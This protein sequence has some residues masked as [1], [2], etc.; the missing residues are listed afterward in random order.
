[1][2]N[3][4]TNEERNADDAFYETPESRAE[5]EERERRMRRMPTRSADEIANHRAMWAGL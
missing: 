1:M 4:R 5:T 3:G 2:P